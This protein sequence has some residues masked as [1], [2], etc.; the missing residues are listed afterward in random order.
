MKIKSIET[1]IIAVPYDHGGPYGSF[2]GKPWD[3][4]ETLL[5]RVETD[6]GLVGWGEAFGHATNPTTKVSPTST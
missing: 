5:V 2:A 4:M 1:T 6:D 3:R